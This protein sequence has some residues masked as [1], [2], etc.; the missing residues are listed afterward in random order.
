MANIDEPSQRRRLTAKERGEERQQSINEWQALWDTTP[1]GRWTHMLIRDVETL[2]NRK[3]FYLTQFLNVHGC[4]REY[5]YKYGH[6]D[7]AVCS[8]CGSERDNA[9]HVFSHC[10]RYNTYRINLET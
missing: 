5:L 2:F 6:D 7:A 4:F 1:K 10:P 9:K 3:H 8:S